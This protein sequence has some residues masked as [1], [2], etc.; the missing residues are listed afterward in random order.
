MKK[1]ASLLLL[2]TVLAS[3]FL[4]SGHNMAAKKKA[5]I[6]KIPLHP[7]ATALLY[8]ATAF[9]L[10]LSLY[11]FSFAKPS[12]NW[13]GYL[14]YTI[15]FGLEYLFG[16]GSFLIPAYLVWLAVRS[17]NR[18]RLSDLFYDHL[19]FFILLGSICFLFTATA[20]QFPSSL[21]ALKEKVISETI[22]IASSYRRTLVRYNLGGVPFYFLYAD[23]P[24]INLQKILSPAGCFLIFS[25]LGI[26]SFSLFTGL[27]F[28]KGAKIAW[29]ASQ[30]IGSVLNSSIRSLWTFARKEIAAKKTPKIAEPR[31]K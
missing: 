20:E 29:R 13:L 23:L 14:G 27:K 25:S 15:A 6:K 8:V 2:G 1:G 21:I 7:D 26:V 16:L 22:S 11:S 24:G 5:K 9:L 18:Q 4:P 12:A 17:L 28:T 31:L 10:F 19:Y 30:A 3:A